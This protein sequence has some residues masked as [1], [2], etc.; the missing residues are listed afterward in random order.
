M[1]LP[2][3]FMAVGQVKSVVKG[4]S[5]VLGYLIFSLP[6]Q[7]NAPMPLI[8]MDCSYCVPVNVLG[9]AQISSLLGYSL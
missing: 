8:F 5:T 1:G 6:L 4:V 7:K 9:T 3:S 2:Q